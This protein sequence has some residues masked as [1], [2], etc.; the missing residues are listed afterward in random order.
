MNESIQNVYDHYPEEYRKPLLQIRELIYTVA[1]E[2]SGVGELEESLKWGQPTYSTV[3]PKTGTP[4]RLDRFGEDKIG[5]FV[6]CQTSLI[7]NFRQLFGN[8]LEFTDN[9]GIIIDPKKKLPIKELSFCI[10]MALTYHLK[11]S[12]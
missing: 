12:K 1:S 7:E 2:M 8:A 5:I 4:I 3:K 9:R 10:G 6:H 11:K